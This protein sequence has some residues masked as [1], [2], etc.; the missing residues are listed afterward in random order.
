MPQQGSVVPLICLLKRVR[1]VTRI[2]HCTPHI[3]TVPHRCTHSVP[4][5]SLRQGRGRPVMT[6][7]NRYRGLYSLA[8]LC[9][10]ILFLKCWRSTGTPNRRSE[11]CKFDLISPHYSRVWFTMVS[12]LMIS[13]SS[14]L[15]LLVW[16]AG[17]FLFGFYLM[18]FSR[19]TT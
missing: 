17:Y 16:S 5:H 6:G 10:G 15:Q 2:C 8:N 3:I 9:A 12:L 4:S 1:E 19:T 14:L 13:E 11:P 7:G 18:L